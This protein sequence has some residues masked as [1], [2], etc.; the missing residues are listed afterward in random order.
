[1][2]WRQYLYKQK[3]DNY[4]KS[5]SLGDKI[6]LLIMKGK[7]NNFMKEVDVILDGYNKITKDADYIHAKEIMDEELRI[8]EQLLETNSREIFP[9]ICGIAMISIRQRNAE[10]F[11]QKMY[12]S[13]GDLVTIV[14]KTVTK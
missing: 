1:M 12:E 7:T 13:I 4:F 3:R 6:D 11:S 2:Y 8:I 10:L 9:L 14:G 5:I